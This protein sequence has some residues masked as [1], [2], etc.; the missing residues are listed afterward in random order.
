MRQM[1]WEWLGLQAVIWKGPNDLCLG[2]ESSPAS[3]VYPSLHTTQ[4]RHISGL[5]SP[6]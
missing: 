4:Q 5:M 3:A 1:H 2:A 6:V